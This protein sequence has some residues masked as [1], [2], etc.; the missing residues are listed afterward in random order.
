VRDWQLTTWVMAQHIFQFKAIILMEYTVIIII[1]NMANA[2][3]CESSSGW[4]YHVHLKLHWHC[5]WDFYSVHLQGQVT[6]QLQ[7]KFTAHREVPFDTPSSSQ[8]AYETE[9]GPLKSQSVSRGSRNL[10]ETLQCCSLHR[11]KQLLNT[12][13]CGI[14]N[15]NTPVY[16]W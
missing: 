1:T 6:T 9:N 4:W 14:M 11:A 5:F 7:H 10:G 2:W 13:F 8:A 12:H 15:G 3:E 16:S